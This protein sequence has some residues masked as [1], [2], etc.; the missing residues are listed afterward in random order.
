MPSLHLFSVPL[1]RSSLGGQPWV[2]PPGTPVPNLFPVG[3]RVPHSQ[4]DPKELSWMKPS[5][6]RLLTHPT[7]MITSMLELDVLLIS[8]GEAAACWGALCLSLNA[9]YLGVLTYIREISL[10]CVRVCALVHVCLFLHVCTHP[11]SWCFLLPLPRT[12]S[13]EDGVTVYFHAI[14]SRDFSFNPDKHR[15]CVRGGAGLGKEPWS[16]ACEMNYTK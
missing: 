9:W 15:V 4:C 8:W 14:V 6:S 7:P 2:G 11:R 5:L 10:V 12:L 16:D 1:A 13:P 3:P